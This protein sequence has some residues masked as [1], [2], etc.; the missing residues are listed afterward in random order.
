MAITL[1]RSRLGGIVALGFVG[2][3]MALIYISIGAP[4]LAMT[5]FAIETL[6]VVLFVLILIVC[7][8][9]IPLPAG[10]TAAD[11]LIAIAAGGLMTLLVLMAALVSG[12]YPLE[13]PFL[14]QQL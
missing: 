11:A 14:R 7:P 1:F 4:D 5:Q 10:R 9:S 12:R 13:R 2:Y 6:T 8:A 3:G